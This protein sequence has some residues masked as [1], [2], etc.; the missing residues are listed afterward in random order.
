MDAIFVGVDVPKD[1][2][3]VY[4]RP[5][6]EAFAVARDGK[7][8]EEAVARLQAISPTL[9]AVEA[10]G[11]FES[12]VAAPLAGAQLPLMV[13]N[14]AQIDTSRRRLASAPRRSD[15]CGDHRAVCR[16]REAGAA[17][18]AGRSAAG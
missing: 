17:C 8:L 2:L 5:S 6:G 15:R 14:P 10:T 12:I 3:D 16:G 11:G 13:V 1:Q 7:G 4:V 9:I 18:Y